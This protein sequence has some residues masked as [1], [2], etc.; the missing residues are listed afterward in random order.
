M[1]H[2]RT[3]LII[4]TLE[5]RLKLF[6][7]VGL[8][9]ARQTGKSTTLRD[10]LSQ[11]RKLKYISLDR[12]ENRSQATEQPTLFIQQAESAS[13]K[14]LCTLCIDEIQKAPVLFD[15]LKAEVDERRQPGRFMISGST[16]F[17]KKTGIQESLTGRIALLRLFPLNLQEIYLK[18]KNFSLKEVRLWADRGGMPGFFAIRDEAA[19]ESAVEQWIETTCSR[20][21]ANF[22]INRFNPDLARRIFFEVAS[23]A[24]PNRLE[25]ARAVGKTPRQIEAYLQGFKALFVIYEI[26]PHPTS[27]GKPLFYIFDSGIAKNMG[28]SSHRCLQTWFLNQCYSTQSYSGKIRPDIFHYE[29]TRGSKIDFLV[30]AKTKTEAYKIFEKEAPTTYDLRAVHA[31][32]VKH[33]T[34]STTALAPCLMEHSVSKKIKIIPWGSL[35]FDG[36]A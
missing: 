28:A 15:T 22:K 33:K 18:K 31:F 10:Q 27:V 30:Q 11:I 24:N 25:I 8:L 12:D 4:P 6:P 26:E 14:T 7:I 17:S 23:S 19:R 9:G 20:D 35:A 16:E 34:I 5:K 36:I 13:I 32:E 1:R 2:Q 29:T 21:L 3:R